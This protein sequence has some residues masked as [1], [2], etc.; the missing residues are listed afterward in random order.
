M[1]LYDLGPPSTLNFISKTRENDPDTGGICT[2]VNMSIYFPTVPSPALI[3]HL[4]V[5]WTWIP[6]TTRRSITLNQVTIDRANDDVMVYFVSVVINSSENG[7]LRWSSAETMVIGSFGI[8]I[9]STN[10]E[11]T[12]NVTNNHSEENWYDI[13]VSIGHLVILL[14]ILI[15]ILLF[16]RR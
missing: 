10:E 8:D 14:L 15:L 5:G 7:L 9:S 13:H 2:K 4:S 11:P 6:Y 16:R 12:N 1:A 3:G